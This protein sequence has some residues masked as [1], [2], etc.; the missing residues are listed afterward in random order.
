MPGPVTGYQ[1]RTEAD[2]VTD[3]ILIALGGNAILRP[4]QRGT[5]E[6]QVETLQA[7]SVAVAGLLAA[8]HRLVLT[9]GNGP[10]VGN[11]LIQNELAR[12]RVPAMPLAACGAQSQ[13]LIG[14]MC[15]LAL[16]AEFGRRGL[17]VP[18]VSVVT[19]VTVDA[20][21]PAFGQPTKPVGPYFERAEAERLERQEGYS[22]VEDSGRGWRRVV[23]SPDP[24]SIVESAAIRTLVESGTLVIAAGGGGIPVDLE[25]QPVAAVIDK[26]LTAQLLARQ[27][28]AG[29]LIILTDVAAAALD[30]GT[31]SQ[32]DLGTIGAGQARE[33]LQQ[34]QFAAG[35]MGPKVEAGI[36]FAASGGEAVITSLELLLEAVEG[37]AGTRIVPD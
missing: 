4:G 13:G 21:D 36:Q 27:L 7:V 12:D 16:R 19:T 8:G 35:S 15:Q 32:R 25:G 29:Q 6:Q 26:D 24:V 31:A 10:Q 33:H 5:F 2:V 28:G 3:L 18:V 37:R 14:F 23:A 17:Q 20:D 9:H 22:M 1:R 11:I 34:G 30:F